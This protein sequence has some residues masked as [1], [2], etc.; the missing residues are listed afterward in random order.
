MGILGRVFVMVCF[1]QLLKNGLCRASNQGE[2]TLGEGRVVNCCERWIEYERA[3]T[4]LSWVDALE[5]DA[6]CP[7]IDSV[8]ENDSL[9]QSE[10]NLLRE[11]SYFWRLEAYH[12]GANNCFRRKYKAHS[13]QCCYSSDGR[14]ITDG[15]GGGTADKASAPTSPWVALFQ[16]IKG[17]S[18]RHYDLDVRPFIDCGGSGGWDVY[19]TVRPI[20]N[21]RLL[22]SDRVCPENPSLQRPG[23]QYTPMLVDDES[24]CSFQPVPV[25]E[26]NL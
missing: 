25:S 22:G 20:S 24:K 7:C 3:S 12:P 26:I 2:G 15:P 14:L 13:Q 8:A 11:M 16:V 1:V 6:P 9:W 18:L 17:A 4:D 23:V 5:S 19:R 10:K 21:G